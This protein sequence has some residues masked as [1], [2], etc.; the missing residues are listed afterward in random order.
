MYDKKRN[1]KKIKKRR[2][3]RAVFLTALICA[4]VSVLVIVGALWFVGLRYVS[5][6]TADGTKIK[7]FGMVDSDGTPM[8]GKIVYSIG[9]IADV[10]RDRDTISYSDG[11][12]YSGGLDG[13]LKSGQGKMYYANGDIYE[14]E[15]SG[16][17]INGH[18]V[19]SYVNGDVYEGSFVNSEKS[20]EANTHGRTAPSMRA[21]S[22][23]TCATVTACSPRR[24][25]TPTTA[26]LSGIRNPARANTPGQTATPTR[27][28]ISTIC[29]PARVR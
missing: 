2:S 10:D 3:F 15:W 29:A 11:S 23:R 20:G 24:E 7:F 14:G 21:R 19:Y 28:R 27:E 22:T 26:A 18:G 25:A 12:S 1:H 8:R 17:M 16:D 6:N 9:L 13:L 4:A 5:L